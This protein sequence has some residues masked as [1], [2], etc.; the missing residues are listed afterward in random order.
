[1]SEGALLA[2]K[3]LGCGVSR[4]GWARIQHQDNVTSHSSDSSFDSGTSSGGGWIQV[5]REIF[6]KIL[7]KNILP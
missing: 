2:G 7:L 4:M 6:D 1:M 3:S 5:N